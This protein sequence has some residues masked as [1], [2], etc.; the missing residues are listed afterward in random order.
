MCLMHSTLIYLITH[1]TNFHDH[2]LAPLADTCLPYLS[3]SRPP[4]FPCMVSCPYALTV[5]DVKCIV[6][7]FRFLYDSYYYAL[8]NILVCAFTG[9]TRSMKERPHTS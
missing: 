4:I 6:Y 8:P 3:H 9:R 7:L 5:M 2:Y 1:L